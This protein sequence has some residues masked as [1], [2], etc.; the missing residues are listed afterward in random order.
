MQQAATTEERIRLAAR[1]DEL[2]RKTE[3]QWDLRVELSMDLQEWIPPTLAHD[4]LSR[5]SHG[6][7]Y[8]LWSRHLTISL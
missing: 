4:R 6:D 3:R 8:M 7:P 1:I 2:A 5:I